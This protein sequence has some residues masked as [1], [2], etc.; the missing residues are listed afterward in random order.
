MR[1]ELN[2][3]SSCLVVCSP[4]VISQPD[5]DHNHMSLPVA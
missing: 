4:P 1:S 5:N 3:D 2:M